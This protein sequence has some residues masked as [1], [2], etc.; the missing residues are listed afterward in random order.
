MDV[1][2]V[3]P[4]EPTAISS[5]K[6][7]EVLLKLDCNSQ[8]YG[9]AVDGD[10]HRKDIA[11]A[12]VVR[13]LERLVFRTRPCRGDVRQILLEEGETQTGRTLLPSPFGRR[14]GDEG[15]PQNKC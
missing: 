6:W 7:C 10:W 8:T 15:K 4:F 5:R 11:F 3:F 2:Q 13:S 14:V 12:E 9:L 1:D